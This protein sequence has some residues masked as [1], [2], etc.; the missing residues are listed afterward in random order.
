[1]SF[2]KVHSAQVRVLDAAVIDVE[3]DLSG[4][5]HAF[6]IVGLPDKAV[7]EARDRVSSAIKNS[8]FK[9]PK[10][11][12]EKVIISLAPGRGY[13][14]QSSRKIIPR[15]TRAGRTHTSHHRHSAFSTCSSPCGF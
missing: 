11:K 1:M 3:V 14:L 10:K 8:G 15:R 5:L 9:S 12:N 13:S 6:S 2:S 4:G 7:E